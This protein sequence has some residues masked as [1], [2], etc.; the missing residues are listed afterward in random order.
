MNLGI[1]KC[2]SK[3]HSGIFILCT[4]YSSWKKNMQITGVQLFAT[5]FCH[6]FKTAGRIVSPVF[7]PSSYSSWPTFSVDSRLRISKS[8]GQPI[9]DAVFEPTLQHD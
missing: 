7:V 1:K 2:S 6:Y 5:N 3:K 8:H 9:Y 4:D